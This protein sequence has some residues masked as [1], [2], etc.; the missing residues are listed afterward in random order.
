MKVS[1]R[2]LEAFLRRPLDARDLSKRLAMLGAPVDA[3]T[4]VGADLAPF[5]VALVT[6]VRPHPNANKLR[7]TTVDDGSGTLLSVVCGAPNVVAGAKYPFARLGTVMPGGLVIEK[8]KL[9]GE[10]SEGMLCSARELG[11]GEDH[12]GLLILDT[13]AVPGT[14][15]IK[16]LDSGDEQLEIDVTPN[17]PDLLGHKGVARELA[18]S[19]GIPYRLPDIPALSEVDLP[20]PV[21][22]A[23]EAV[24][25]GVR[26]TIADPAGCGRLLGAVIRG[27]TVGASPE[28]L[29]R[30]LESVGA[31]SINNVVDVSNY[32]LFELNQ[33]THTYDANA[34]RGS[35]V[36]VRSAHAGESVVTLDGLSR[37]LA[38]G[39]LVIADAERVIGIAGVMGG[40]DTEVSESTT[41]LFLECAWFDPS[42]VRK[43]RRGVGLSTDASQRFERGTDR[44]GAVEAFRRCIRMIIAV[45]GGAVDGVTIDCTPVPAFPPRIFLRPARV[46]QVLGVALPWVDIE[47]HMVAIGATVVSK[48]DDDRIAVDVPGWRPDIVA[49][50]DLVE[51]IARLHGYENIPVDLRPFRPGHRSDDAAWGAAARVRLGLAALGLA[52]VMTLPMV[53]E[54]GMSAPRLLNPLSAEHG[55]LRTQLLSPLLRLVEA[56][57]ANHVGD[58]RLF[59]VGTV[60]TN[61]GPGEAPRETSHAAFV[62]T[63]ARQPAHWTTAGKAADW[64]I[65]DAKALFEQLVALAQPNATVHLQRDGY[66]V[67]TADTERV[68]GQCAPLD[69]SFGGGLTEVARPDAPAWAGPTFGGY[70]EIALAPQVATLYSPTP[71][72]PASTRDLALLVP[73]TRPVA[74]ITSLLSERGGRYGL[75][76][77]SVVDEYRGKS[78][79][80]GMRSVAVRLVFR[81]ADRTLIDTEVEQAVSRLLTSLERELDATL[82]SS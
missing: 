54:R 79:P 53:S 75:E 61:V 50:I 7:V 49:E 35:A 31:R 21:R 22:F 4:S 52:E 10:L 68:V 15:L 43:S 58:I 29:R 66:W 33:P 70:V 5:V 1:R 47:R 67:A 40:R 65:W 8:R 26:V 42:R 73:L 59:E 48:P 80:A 36:I 37:P 25:G 9:R 12:D 17:R 3:I 30:R 62:V 28:W 63:G 51:E 60:F 18:A 81:A 27:V 13:D 11:L 20:T 14:S 24:V 19:Y 77:V 45:A 57:W 71:V 72:Y 16:V 39:A 69:A 34:L 64:D 82:R 76:S 2:W 41:D 23:E 38:E 55:T 74:D 6:D 32:I 46:T 56:N 44:W 78:L